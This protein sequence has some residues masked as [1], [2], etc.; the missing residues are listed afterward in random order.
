MKRKGLSFL[1]C[2]V[3]LAT[4]LPLQAF[5]GLINP[6]GEK[7]KL[8]LVYL[9]FDANADPNDGCPYNVTSQLP[10]LDKDDTF[11]VGIQMRDFNKIAEATN[12]IN[13]IG[14]GLVYDNTILEFEPNQSN[15]NKPLKLWNERMDYE[16]AFPY[17]G[18]NGYGIQQSAIEGAA[19]ENPPSDKVPSGLVVPFSWINS[20]INETPG[21]N[22]DTDILIAIAEFKV[23]QVPKDGAKV[24]DLADNGTQTVVGFGANGNSGGYAYNKLNNGT[25]MATIV[26]LDTS[27]VDNLFPAAVTATISSIAVD[28]STIPTM[29]AVE[30]AP[31]AISGIRVKAEYEDHTTKGGIKPNGFVI[32][33]SNTVAPTSTTGAITGE[34]ITMDKTAHDGKHLWA[35]YTDTTGK[36]VYA[37]VGELSVSDAVITKIEVTTEPALSYTVGQRADL[38]A[39]GAK[40]T[41][42][43]NTTETVTYGAFASK[44]LTVKVDETTITDES[45]EMTLAMNGKSFTVTNG[46]A[47][48]NTVG[49]ISVV[50]A[51]VTGITF[52]GIVKIS[53]TYGDKIQLPDVK[54]SNDNGTDETVSGSAARVSW[55]LSGSALD[56]DQYYSV[57][58]VNG[59]VLEATVGTEKCSVELAMT[60]KEITVSTVYL[61]EV[62]KGDTI[63]SK[64]ALKF[65]ADG[66]AEAPY[67]EATGIVNNDV[68]TINYEAAADIDTSSIG[69]GKSATVDLVIDAGQDNYTITP[70]SISA[71]YDVKA[72]KGVVTAIT[73]SGSQEKY[74]DGEGLKTDGLNAVVTYEDGSSDTLTGS[75][76]N[77]YLYVGAAA[78]TAVKTAVGTPLDSTTSAIKIFVGIENTGGTTV[79][80]SD[81]VEVH[82]FQHVASLISVK[83][84]GG[85]E[86]LLRQAGFDD[87]GKDFTSISAI[88]TFFGWD[89]ANW[90]DGKYYDKN[91][92]TATAI[93]ANDT[94]HYA[95]T[96]SKPSLYV[97]LNS[98]GGGG[99]KPSGGSGG[100]SVASSITLNK[101]S[102]EGVVGGSET[103]TASLKNVKGT[104][105][106]KSS[107]EKVATVDKNG[108]ITFVG[109]GTATIT[110]S[111]T[112]GSKTY[113]DTVKV[114]VKAKD[115]E[116]KDSMINKDYL[117]P[118]VTGYPGG[119]FLPDKSL[120][121]AEAAAMISKI[122]K[123]P[124]DMSKSYDFSMYTDV[125]AEEWY[126][127]FIGFLSAKG[128]ITG[129]TDKTFRPNEEVSRAELSTM[130]AK[131]EALNEESA[132]SRL[133]DVADHWAA[134]YINAMSQK[135]YISGYPDGT[136]LPN[137]AV[138][139]AE[140]VT[141]INSMLKTAETAGSNAPTDMD[142]SHWAYNAVLKAMNTRIA[143]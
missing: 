3:M 122:L 52:S 125:S 48:V 18:A 34:T 71:T 72:R 50:D 86:T 66:S 126:G 116:V 88:S 82:F 113:T 22:G 92:S 124:I 68:V 132:N 23:L 69:T 109:V 20:T 39:F 24:L 90:K 5:A 135:G 115:E 81:G 136:F 42:D 117:Q 40:L 60:K 45:T 103:V 108:K 83:S 100:G 64:G 119:A 139:R 57:D 26:D 141:V 84:L 114:T 53:Y 19:Q 30:G 89:E 2:I 9:T 36:T 29:S 111:V 129:Y 27:A 62:E 54:I 17:C 121:R 63:A 4:M 107:D 77:N 105:T 43:N 47:T 96:A 1:I 97:V 76:L 67:F 75:A 106:W 99:S 11:Y 6:D 131:A 78:G 123:D 15:R 120:T 41:Y 12:G 91:V 95:I 65:N 49:T 87:P 104:V 70:T 28:P 55:T 44:G 33:E 101:S 98:G 38:K 46:T 79:F 128:I 102:V 31:V 21:Y 140:T 59:A 8:S 93:E 73:L 80:S 112:E 118:Y 58:E 138:T 143:Q 130:L 37:Y 85:A 10:V 32:N 35:Y 13:N 51:T 134:K 7:A 25:D 61:G 16:G 94:T 127:N 74:Y 110:A 142:A 137:K 133:I 14:T 56:A